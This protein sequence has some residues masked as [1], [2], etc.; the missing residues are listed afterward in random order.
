MSLVL[1]GRG[2]DDWDLA[3]E[4]ALAPSEAERRYLL[5]RRREVGR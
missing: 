4:C 2:A 3:E 5:G 1:R